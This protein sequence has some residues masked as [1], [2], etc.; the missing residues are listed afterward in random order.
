MLEPGEGD[1]GAACF[2]KRG[3]KI[4]VEV[5]GEEEKKGAPSRDS[6]RAL[7]LVSLS[8]SLCKLG[9]E[10][11]KNALTFRVPLSVFEQ[12]DAGDGAKG[13]EERGELELLGVVGELRL[14]VLFCGKRSIKNERPRK[15]KEK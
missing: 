2:G 11:E 3:E 7:S 5:V 8:L 1:E 13:R 15:K 10:K 14:A 4:G 6:F 9:T 12:L